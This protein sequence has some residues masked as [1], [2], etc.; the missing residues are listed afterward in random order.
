M[1]PVLEDQMKLLNNK[2]T[3]YVKQ[4]EVGSGH[5]NKANQSYQDVFYSLTRFS[6][7]DK[8]QRD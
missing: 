6:N 2:A 7:L 5:S 8:N 3:E 1:L 4:T